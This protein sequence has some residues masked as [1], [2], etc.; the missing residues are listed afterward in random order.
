MNGLF[1]WQN[2]KKVPVVKIYEIKRNHPYFYR[3]QMQ[4]L[5]TRATV[6]FLFGQKGKKILTNVLYGWMQIFPFN[7][8]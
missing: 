3:M 5:L 6:I 1:N 8:S 4:M 2:D 7:K